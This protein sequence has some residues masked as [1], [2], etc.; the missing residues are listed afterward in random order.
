MISDILEFAPKLIGALIL[1]FVGKWVAGFIR[2]LV[3]KALGAV[4]FDQVVDKAG[5]G[6][7]LE[8]AGFA[9]SALLLARIVGWM[10]M[11]IFVQI[12]VRTLGIDSISTLINEFVAWIPNVIIA[13][14]LIVIT[15]AVANFV[16][17]ILTDVLAD[18]SMGDLLMKVVIAG[19]WI[20]G[21]MMAIDQLGFGRDIIDQ[22]WNALT[23][24]L[25]AILVIKFGIGGI[26]A[27]RDRFWPKVYDAVDADTKA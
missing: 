22:L 14:I 18:V 5:L 9:D 27:A 3:H 17:G 11:L 6:A 23:T 1:L 13:I 21:G 7:P 8:S 2:G 4:K 15:G 16:R 20:L 12:A 19:I 26:W 25:A 24:G 10:I